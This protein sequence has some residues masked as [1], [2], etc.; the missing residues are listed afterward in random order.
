LIERGGEVVPIAL[1]LQEHRVHAIGQ[2]NVVELI[3]AAE[4]IVAFYGDIPT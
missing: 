3:E 4:R 2:E 1:T